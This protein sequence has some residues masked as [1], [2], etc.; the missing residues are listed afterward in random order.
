MPYQ[1]SAW[2]YLRLVPG[3]KLEYGYNS[4]HA[5]DPDYTMSTHY[6]RKTCQGVVDRWYA[7]QRNLFRPQYVPKDWCY[8]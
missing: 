5:A 7:D 6:G 4:L 1:M 2:H 3:Y 8:E